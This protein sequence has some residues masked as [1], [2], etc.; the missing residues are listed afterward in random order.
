MQSHA[1]GWDKGSLPLVTMVAG[2]RDEQLVWNRR[3]W[4]M[5]P[6]TVGLVYSMGHVGEAPSL[7]G[8]ASRA[9]ISLLPSLKVPG[10]GYDQ[11]GSHG[12]L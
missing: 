9:L 4:R 2:R 11:V 5:V 6:S 10:K 8:V 12:T 3:H 7:L 1:T